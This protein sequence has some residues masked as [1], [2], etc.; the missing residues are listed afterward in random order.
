MI[1]HPLVRYLQVNFSVIKGMQLPNDTSRCSENSGQDT[2]NPT[3]VG[4]GT[5]LAVE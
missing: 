3:V 2:S 5:R 1:P 4:T